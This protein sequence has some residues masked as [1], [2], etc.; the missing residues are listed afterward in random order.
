MKKKVFE[1]DDLVAILGGSM[2]KDGNVAD[3]AEIATVIAVGKSDL[4]VSL[5]GSKSFGQNGRVVTVPMGLCQKLK[6]S[7]DRLQRE[8]VLEPRTGDQVLSLTRSTYG[9]DEDKKITGVVYSIRHKLG[10]PDTVVIMSGTDFIDVS[11]SSLIV[12]SRD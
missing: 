11:Y 10:Q 5:T 1:K 12:L 8:K 4:L 3:T 9:S 7:P 6:I 2:G